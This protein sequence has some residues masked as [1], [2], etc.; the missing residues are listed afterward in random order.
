MNADT[1]CVVSDLAWVERLIA[2]HPELA[3]MKQEVI[4]RDGHVTVK[5]RGAYREAMAWRSAISGRIYPSHV[6]THGARQQLVVGSGV[7]VQIVERSSE[8][9]SAALIHGPAFAWK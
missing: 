2:I 9:E 3:G 8:H 1:H 5:V 4:E 7:E 6:D